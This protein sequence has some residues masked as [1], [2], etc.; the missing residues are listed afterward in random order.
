MDNNI[1]LRELLEIYINHFASLLDSEQFSTD[2]LAYQAI[3]NPQ[4]YRNILIPIPFYAL[5]GML[6][7]NSLHI[8]NIDLTKLS[9]EKQF[10]KS[11]KS[12]LRELNYKNIKE[13]DRGNKISNAYVK[14][15]YKDESEI[16]NHI[17]RSGIIGLSGLFIISLIENIIITFYK[18]LKFIDETGKEHDKTKGPLKDFVESLRIFESKATIQSTSYKVPIEVT[19]Y[20]DKKNVP[21]WERIKNYCPKRRVEIN[22]LANIHLKK[23]KA[24]VKDYPIIKSNT[25]KS[26]IID[27][28][29]EDIHLSEYM[30]LMLHV[31]KELNITEKNQPS[32]DDLVDKL[33]ENQTEYNITS[34]SD[35]I[36][37]SMVTII[38]EEKS[39]KGGNKKLSKVSKG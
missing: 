37:N 25:I 11:T 38:R 19:I 6:A 27:K 30:K 2:S 10:I 32:K 1:I 7:I 17:R 5:Y 8:I 35:N 16:S 14:Y 26:K 36:I 22:K 33:K 9:T 13:H 29:G 39:Q 18:N 12:C 3:I 34:L 15:Y 21:D 20:I 4:Q 31:I 24:S 23:E 28:I